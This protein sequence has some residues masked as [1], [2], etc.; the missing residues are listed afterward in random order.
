M[1]FENLIDWLFATRPIGSVPQLGVADASKRALIWLPGKAAKPAG[2][3]VRSEDAKFLGCTQLAF[4]DHH[5]AMDSQ[6]SWV[7]AA[8]IDIDGSDNPSLKTHRLIDAVVEATDGMPVS[9]RLSCGGRGLHVIQRVAY[10]VAIPAYPTRGMKS[11]VV[12]SI[13]RPAVA[14]LEAAGIHVCKSDCRMFWLWGG[15]NSWILQ[16]DELLNANEAV[17]V[18][19]QETERAGGEIPV[20][21]D[22]GVVDPFVAE[23]LNRLGVAPG[24]V[25]VGAVVAR[26]RGLG[27][28]VNTKS[29][30]TGNGEINGYVDVRPGEGGLWS[31]ADGRTIWR[32]VDESRMLE[33]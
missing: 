13:N 16:T 20:R 18:S 11:S 5:S 26:L 12:K 8:M 14:A 30:M 31:Y 24:P 7:C 22:G 15:E 19:A 27:E 21:L 9:I 4:E 3:T 25:Y 6:R 29:P 28:T 33:G 10:P 23:W 32:A 2:V 17:R 1:T